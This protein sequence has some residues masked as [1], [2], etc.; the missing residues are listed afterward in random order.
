MPVARDLMQANPLTVRA[1]AS[2][3][4]IQQLLVT[5][6]ISGAPV[7]GS[8]GEVIGVL[9]ATDVLRAMAEALDEDR[10]EGEPD[11]VLERIEAVTAADIATPD[12][13][14]VAADASPSEVAKLMRSEGIHRVLVGTEPRLEGILTAFDLLKVI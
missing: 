8:R 5:A 14:W 1:T 4:D 6:G 13:I 3:L 7:V 10:E 11:D 2:L 12:A 9:S